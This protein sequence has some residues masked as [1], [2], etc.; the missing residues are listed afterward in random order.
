MLRSFCRALALVLCLT[1]P[2][3]AEVVTLQSLATGQPVG[4]DSAGLL[5]LGAGAAVPMEMIRL[6]GRRVAFRDPASG[7][8]LRAGIGA[9]TEMALVSPHI[10]GWETFE[11]WDQG[12]SVSLRSVQSGQFVGADGRGQRLN[13][14]WGSAGR[15]QQFQLIPTGAAPRPLPPR[16]PAAVF[17]GQWRVQ[18]LYVNGQ[19]QPLSMATR[20]AV[21]LG[22]DRQGGA[23]GNTGCNA[24]DGRVTAEGGGHRIGGIMMTRRGCGG[25]AGQVERLLLEAFG[26]TRLLEIQGGRLI[27]RGE[28]GRLLARFAPH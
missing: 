26:A 17:V 16:P 19:S 15:A 20:A 24:F 3:F 18:D 13:A 28:G 27:L 12:G 23:Q 10:R 11:L 4:R 2:A 21:Q 6:D 22:I 1:A 9:A 5:R 14:T 8:F 25:E 7:L